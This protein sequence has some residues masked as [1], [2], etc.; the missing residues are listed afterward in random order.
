[1]VEA[2]QENGNPSRFIMSGSTLVAILRGGDRG[3]FR[4]RSEYSNQQF[5]DMISIHRQHIENTFG[6]GAFERVQ[7]FSRTAGTAY[8]ELLDRIIRMTVWATILLY[9]TGWAALVFGAVKFFSFPLLLTILLMEL[10][11][12]VTA[13]RKRST[14]P[15]LDEVFNEVG[16]PRTRP[17]SV[18]LQLLAQWSIKLGVSVACYYATDIW[19]S[20]VAHIFNEMSLGLIFIYSTRLAL[21]VLSRGIYG[22]VATL[23]VLKFPTLIL[24]EQVIFQTGA[25]LLLRCNDIDSSL[26]TRRY[27][28]IT[29]EK[30]ASNFESS[31]PRALRLRIHPHDSSF[32]RM[33]SI[34]NYIRSLKVWVAFPQQG[35]AQAMADELSILISAIATQMYHYLPI[36]PVEEPLVK[37]K[38]HLQIAKFFG[39]ILAAITPLAALFIVRLGGIEL[40]NKITAVWTIAGSVWIVIY[41]ISL[42]DPKYSEKISAA[43]E[44]IS[45][46]ETK[47]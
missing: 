16:G 11:D 18:Y 24:L 47:R 31:I 39:S 25:R 36:D 15:S 17:R 14:N 44:I 41:A 40:D 6:T 23:I 32:Q 20:G 43:K 19:S 46:V 45:I 22:A 38:W 9:F 4:Q 34:A 7:E 30:M 29:L 37:T 42:F 3:I 26:S 2:P 28:S 21:G 33:L 5:D 13:P 12:A 10:Y 8:S 35:T 1:M 27:F